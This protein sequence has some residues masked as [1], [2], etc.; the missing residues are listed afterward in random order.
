MKN[1]FLTLLVPVKDV[2]LDTRR[3]SFVAFVITCQ[4][5]HCLVEVMVLFIEW[6]GVMVANS[7]SPKQLMNHVCV[8]CMTLNGRFSAWYL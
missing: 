5:S 1:S 6:T 3:L 8:L 2:C 4:S 7:M